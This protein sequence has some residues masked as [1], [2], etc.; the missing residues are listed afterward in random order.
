MKTVYIAAPLGGGEQREVNRLRAER[1]VCWAA[2]AMGVAPVATWTTLAAAWDES[3][4]DLGLAIDVAL[5]ER[6][7]EIWMVGGRISPGMMIEG[8]HSKRIIDLTGWGEEPESI[9]QDVIEVAR[10]IVRCDF[11]V[12][13]AVKMRLVEYIEPPEGLAPPPG[14][15]RWR[16]TAR[17]EAL[18]EALR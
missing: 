4:R 14:E 11:S 3:K 17:G 1:W 7:D 18:M 5:V 8:R 6:C 15:K 2:E 9:S 16:I 10:D 12:A 13:R